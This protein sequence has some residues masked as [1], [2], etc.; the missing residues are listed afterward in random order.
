MS[1]RVVAF[2]PLAAF[3]RKRKEDAGDQRLL[4]D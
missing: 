2:E 4:S 1:S 3:P